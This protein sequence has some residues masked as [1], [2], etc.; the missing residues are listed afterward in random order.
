MP[1]SRGPCAVPAGLGKCAGACKAET[2]ERRSGSRG[3]FRRPWPSHCTWISIKPVRTF[4]H[5]RRKHSSGR[6]PQPSSIGATVRSKGVA[7]ARYTASSSSLRTLSRCCSP[8]TIRTRG[9]DFSTLPHSTAIPNMRRNTC[10]SRLMLETCKPSLRRFAT[11]VVI[12]SL[13]MALSLRLIFPRIV[14]A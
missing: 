13:V 11:Y 1:T 9:N 2:V 5:L 4:S 8:G 6:R 3:F 12:F 7:F 14:L 10:S